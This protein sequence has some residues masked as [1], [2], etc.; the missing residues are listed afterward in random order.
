MIFNE[1]PSLQELGM[2]YLISYLT[3]IAGLHWFMKTKSGFSDVL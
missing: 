3:M 2:V 1:S